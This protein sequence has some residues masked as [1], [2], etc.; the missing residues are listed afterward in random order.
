M[1]AK[2]LLVVS[3]LVAAAVSANA[4]INLTTSGAFTLGGIFKGLGAAP[5]YTP[6]SSISSIVLGGHK[7]GAASLNQ[8]W[9]SVAD[10]SDITSV[11]YQITLS[12]ITSKTKVQGE[13]TGQTYIKG[14]I[15]PGMYSNTG[16]FNFNVDAA[17]GSHAFTQTLDFTEYLTTG[18]DTDF[19]TYAGAGG[20]FATKSAFYKGNFTFFNVVPEPTSVAALAIGAL[21]L[22]IRRRRSN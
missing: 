16:N 13:I 8:W 2:R 12:G 22:V 19:D 7:V 5:G 3:G 21:G 1:N 20:P 9:F 10:S 11:T 17:T 18:T 14:V 4:Q 6:G 15:G